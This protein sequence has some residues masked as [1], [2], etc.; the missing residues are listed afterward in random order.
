MN[1]TEPV[2][3]TS[4]TLKTSINNKLLMQINRQEIERIIDLHFNEYVESS[5]EIKYIDVTSKD[6]VQFKYLSFK[7]GINVNPPLSCNFN[8]FHDV[9]IELE[10]TVSPIDEK[11]AF[12]FL[13]EITEKIEAWYD[14]YS[15]FLKLMYVYA[16]RR[17]TDDIIK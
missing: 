14:E 15:A 4:V 10:I 1:E 3:I 2:H 11:R 16:C 13:E 6:M 7:Y 17:K 8:K 5:D 12:M 9:T